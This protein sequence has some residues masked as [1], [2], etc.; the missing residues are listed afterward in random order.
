AYSLYQQEVIY[1]RHRHRYEFNNAYRSLLID[2]GYVVSGTSPDGRLI[3]IIELREH[4]FFIATQFHPEFCSRP[5]S[6]HPLFLGFVKAAVNHHSTHLIQTNED[7]L[8]ISPGQL[9][10]SSP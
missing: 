3:E 6:S 4:P 1:E 8:P 2:T 9:R 7:E 10:V 5:N